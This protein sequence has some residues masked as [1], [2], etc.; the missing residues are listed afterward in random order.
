MLLTILFFSALLSSAQNRNL[1]I[2][3][4]VSKGNVYYDA[5]EDFL[6]D[7][8]K[9]NLI[10]FKPL[11]YKKGGIHKSELDMV[12]ILSIHGWTLISTNQEVYQ[13]S[14]I[15][16]RIMYVLKKQLSVSEET[17]QDIVKRAMKGLEE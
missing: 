7:S 17:Y 11:P 12:N 5:L 1:E 6:P 3:C 15:H 8:L 9:N 16:S 4:Y 10:S 14:D 13:I 2:V